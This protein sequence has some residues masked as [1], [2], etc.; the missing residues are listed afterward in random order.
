[1]RFGQILR[2]A[3]G[4]VLASALASCGQGG[5]PAPDAYAIVIL[6]TRTPRP[7][8]LPGPTPVNPGTP[9]PPPAAPTPTPRP[10][11]Q[12]GRCNMIEIP[13]GWHISASCSLTE[14][15]T[16][17]AGPMVCQIQRNSCAFSL[18]IDNRDPAIRYLREEPP[19]YNDEDSLMHPAMLS[20]LTRLREAVAREWE[21]QVE[22]MVTDTYDSF[23]DHDVN[24]PNMAKKFALHFEGRS[25]DLVTWPVEPARY[26]R[27][28]AL[29]L[30][31]GFDWV[32][33]ETDH[34]HASIKAKSLCEVCLGR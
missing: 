13:D 27:L 25:I 31:A 18:L 33:N 22:L 12:P 28:C 32:H 29:A 9:I 1:M 24:Q 11:G 17:A 6:P 21:G 3:C 26:P 8:L 5:A 7:V 20:P 30:T 10:G 19:P 14:S 34:C 16:A 23:G 15:E 4:L 2:M